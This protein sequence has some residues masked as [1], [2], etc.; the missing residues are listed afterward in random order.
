MND[1]LVSIIIPA[2]NEEMTIDKVLNALQASIGSVEQ[3][4]EVILV[5]NDSADSTALIAKRHGCKV[6]KD[7]SNSI[8]KLRNCGGR[9]ARGEILAFLD[10]DCAVDPRWIRYCLENFHDHT[11]AIVGTR[12]IPDPTNATWVETAWYNLFTGS[13]RPDY[14]EWIGTSNLF[15]RK[16]VFDEI[17]GFNAQLETAE[18]VD[19]CRRVRPRHRIFLEKRI[20][21]IHLRESKTV[22]ELFRRELRRGMF[23]LRH[24]LT[25]NAKVDD[26]A[27]TFMP[28]IVAIM[29]AMVLVVLVISGTNIFILPIIVCLLLMPVALMI[30]KRAIV[31]NL[32]EFAK[33]YAVSSVYILARAVSACKELTIIVLTKYGRIRRKL[34]R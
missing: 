23:S 31:A 16:N 18:D 4:C 33:V 3:R 25:S 10:A 27:S 8:S 14:P 11:I 17:A 22:G 1:P 7:F 30:K 20:D 24:F 6:V 19:F 5:D 13:E 26:F 29:L 28:L 34:D 21:T 15:V 9:F 2:K 12:A 32:K